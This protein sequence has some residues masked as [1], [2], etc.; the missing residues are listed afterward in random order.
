M[1][2]EMVQQNVVGSFMFNKLLHMLAL[3]SQKQS[4]DLTKIG[5]ENDLLL[6][7]NDV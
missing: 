7:R 1:G 2:K 3:G 4:M 6:Y 5:V